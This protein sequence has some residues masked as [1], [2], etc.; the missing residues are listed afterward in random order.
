MNYQFFSS[1]FLF[2]FP[3]TILGMRD[4]VPE[5]SVQHK[6]CLVEIVVVVKS[7]ICQKATSKV[8]YS[9]WM[10]LSYDSRAFA[11]RSA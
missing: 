5:V 3:E 6:L 7:K 8:T 9:L 1:V 10:L 4:T 2:I 11:C